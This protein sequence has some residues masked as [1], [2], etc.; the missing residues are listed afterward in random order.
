MSTRSYGGYS[1]T[2]TLQVNQCRTECAVAPINAKSINNNFSLIK[3]RLTS[4]ENQVTDLENLASYRTQSIDD[5][6]NEALLILNST[7]P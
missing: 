7:V 1:Q 6:I 5:K 4:L 3:E 2:K